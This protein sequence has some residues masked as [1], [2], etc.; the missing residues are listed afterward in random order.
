MGRLFSFLHLQADL[1]M[2]F[3]C[4]FFHLEDTFQKG[5]LKIPG[6]LPDLND[7]AFQPGHFDQP[8]C[9]EPD[10]LLGFSQCQKIILPLF[11]LPVHGFQKFQIAFHICQRGPKLMGSICDH[12]PDL[13]LLF[14]Q[15]LVLCLH[16]F[17]QA[18]DL[19]ADFGGQGI[20]ADSRCLWCL[21]VYQFFQGLR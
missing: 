10:L 11:F 19:A 7:P 5:L 3:L 6:F 1:Y 16:D 9:E 8:F 14:A 12:S 2:F 4:L 20:L 15:G 17:P 21:S 13:L 18:E